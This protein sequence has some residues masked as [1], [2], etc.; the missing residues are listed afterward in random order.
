MY[1]NAILVGACICTILVAESL[2][3]IWAAMTLN[4]VMTLKENLMMF[5]QL[6]Y[7]TE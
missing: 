3:P 4:Y 6:T 2:S 7:A 5:I 1:G